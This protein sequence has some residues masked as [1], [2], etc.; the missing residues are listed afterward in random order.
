MRVDERAGKSMVGDGPDQCLISSTELKWKS[1]P[2]SHT[3]NPL[4]AAASSN[5]G[6]PQF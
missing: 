4:H 6:L 2:L 3:W 1:R 5:F